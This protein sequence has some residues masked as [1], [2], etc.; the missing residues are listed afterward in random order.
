MS[1]AYLINVKVVHK[2]VRRQSLGFI[3]TLPNQLRN[4]GTLLFVI[5]CTE[6]QGRSS[7]GM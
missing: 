5:F 6:Q 1:K 4:T 7:L 3:Q 2:E